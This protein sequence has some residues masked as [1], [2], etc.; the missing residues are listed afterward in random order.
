MLWPA[1]KSRYCAGI[2]GESVAAEVDV[3]AEAVVAGAERDDA[4]GDA[5]AVG[6]EAK[7]DVDLVERAGAVAG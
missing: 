4:L 1:K 2:S 6:I 5:V 3:E 7:F